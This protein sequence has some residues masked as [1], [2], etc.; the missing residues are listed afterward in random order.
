VTEVDEED[1]ILRVAKYLRATIPPPP[2]PPV[3]QQ[4]SFA[5]L[6]EGQHIVNLT[7]FVSGGVEFPEG[8]RFVVTKPT[9]LGVTL[10][11][12]SSLI[13]MTTR[14]WKDRF[15]RVRRPSKRKKKT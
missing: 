9:N 14:E 13:P 11:V 6:S 5:S 4:K 3:K 7:P 8:T 2:P 1:H 15:K 10:S 12:D